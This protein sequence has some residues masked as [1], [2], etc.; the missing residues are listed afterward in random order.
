MPLFITKFWKEH[1]LFIFEPQM[2]PIWTYKLDTTT[3]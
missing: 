1:S 3:S 2:P